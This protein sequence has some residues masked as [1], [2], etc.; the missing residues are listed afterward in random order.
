MAVVLVTGFGP[1]PGVA[2]NASG[3]LATLVDG[4]HFGSWQ[5]AG[6]VVETSWQRAWPALQAA[7]EATRP[8]ALVMF[9]VASRPRVE[10]E[11]VARNHAEPRPDC[12]GCLPTGTLLVD[13]GPAELLTTLPAEGLSCS[14]SAGTYLCNAL[15]YQAQLHLPQVPHR[16]F[17]HVP[18]EGLWVGMRCLGALLRRLEG[19]P[20]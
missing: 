17:V 12:D 13:D 14:Q 20:G 1:F 8:Q 16:G 11:S 9:G 2:D 7:V 3:R 15:F 19:R 6:R 10:I 5:V 18:L 4:A